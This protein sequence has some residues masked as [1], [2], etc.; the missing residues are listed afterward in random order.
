MRLTVCPQGSNPLPGQLGLDC[1]VT[2]EGE[3]QLC[4]AANTHA[5]LGPHT[6]KLPLNDVFPIAKLVVR[7]MPQA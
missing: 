7:P 4:T 2:K 6:P 3:S 1:P 5:S